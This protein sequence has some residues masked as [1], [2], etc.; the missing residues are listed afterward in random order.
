MTIP[1][2]CNHVAPDLIKRVKAMSEDKRS[3]AMRAASIRGVT[4]SGYAMP[5]DAGG[6]DWPPS[7]TDEPSELVRQMELANA[8]RIEAKHWQDQSREAD[9]AMIALRKEAI[10]FVEFVLRHTWPERANDLGPETVHSII[11]HHPFAKDHT[12]TPVEKTLLE[13]VE[14]AARRPV[15]ERPTK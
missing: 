7:M 4:T 14:E 10:A 13:K 11:K 9:K 6:S 1:L 5:V 3:L 15:G 2:F 8:A 12:L